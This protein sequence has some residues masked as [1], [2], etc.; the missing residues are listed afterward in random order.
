MKALGPFQVFFYF[1]LKMYVKILAVGLIVVLILNIVLLL[2]EKIS[3]LTFWIIIVV[4]ALIAY[5]VIPRIKK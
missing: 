3:S 5:K 4:S 2:L 1:F